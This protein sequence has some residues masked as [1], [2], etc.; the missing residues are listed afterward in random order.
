MVSYFLQ[1]VLTAAQGGHT[2]AV[3]CLQVINNFLFSADFAGGIK[4]LSFGSHNVPPKLIAD[5]YESSH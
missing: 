2:S 5:L 1:A 3:K 4:V